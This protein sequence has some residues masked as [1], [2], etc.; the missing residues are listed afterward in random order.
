MNTETVR[1]GFPGNEREINHEVAQGSAGRRRANS[2][3]SERRRAGR[4]FRGAPQ[5]PRV[6]DLPRARDGKPSI[7]LAIGVAGHTYGA[8]Y[9][10]SGQYS[11][12]SVTPQ[13]TQSTRSRVRRP[14]AVF[15]YNCLRLFPAAVP[16]DCA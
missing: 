3:R 5:H 10:A 4:I 14:V 16:A 12:P 13:L 2:R 7:T 9:A 15:D 6:P 1:T 11:A 8:G